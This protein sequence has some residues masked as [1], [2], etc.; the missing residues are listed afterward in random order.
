MTK[1]SLTSLIRSL[2]P[3]ITFFIGLG[4]LAPTYLFLMIGNQC[5]TLRDHHYSIDAYIFCAIYFT[6]FLAGVIIGI[7]KKSKRIK[8]K[9]YGTITANIFFSTS[10]IVS[11]FFIY[12]NWLFQINWSIE[13]QLFCFFCSFVSFIFLGFKK[14]K[15]STSLAIYDFTTAS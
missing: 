2:R 10:L 8:R 9:N 5:K 1:E 3:S 7:R 11:I 4:Y 15:R 12:L 6:F 14:W 13:N